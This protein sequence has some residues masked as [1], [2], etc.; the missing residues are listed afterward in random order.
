MKRPKKSDASTNRSEEKDWKG[1]VLTSAVV[2]QRLTRNQTERI[3]LAHARHFEMNANRR[4]DN[5]EEFKGASIMSLRDLL[6][7]TESV[8]PRKHD[9][10]DGVVDDFFLTKIE[11]SSKNPS[12]NFESVQEIEPKKQLTS[13]FSSPDRAKFSYLNQ[14]HLEPLRRADALV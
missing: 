4:D 6:K 14:V 2:N 9:D 3:E 12:K 13:S 5:F 11:Y 7:P 10:G 8:A 1:L